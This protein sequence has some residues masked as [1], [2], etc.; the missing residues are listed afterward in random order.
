MADFKD[1]I[2]FIDKQGVDCTFKTETNPL[3]GN[4]MWWIDPY[5]GMYASNKQNVKSIMKDIRENF[6]LEDR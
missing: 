2:K 3:N 1:E 5:I 4:Q 6:I